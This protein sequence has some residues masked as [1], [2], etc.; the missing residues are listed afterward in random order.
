M[1]NTGSRACSG[2]RIDEWCACSPISSFSSPCGSFLYRI[3]LANKL[4]GMHANRG[5]Q[6]SRPGLPISWN[7]DLLFKLLSISYNIFIFHC[8]QSIILKFTLLWLFTYVYREG[9]GWDHVWVTCN[10]TDYPELNLTCFHDQ[11][12]NI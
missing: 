7:F 8:L 12:Q 3:Q 5:M 4:V 2:L 9:S 1:E 6:K 10:I 11:N